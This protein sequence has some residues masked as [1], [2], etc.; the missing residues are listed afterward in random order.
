[1]KETN[2]A[3]ERETTQ[4]QKQHDSEVFALSAQH[5]AEINAL[6]RILTSKTEH[7]HRLREMMEEFKNES[8]LQER[9]LEAKSDQEETAGQ[10][11]Q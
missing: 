9:Q 7:G 5:V 3:H 10:T 11:V 4:R 2:D 8:A 1:M 6:A